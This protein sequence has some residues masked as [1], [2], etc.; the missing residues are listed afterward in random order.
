MQNNNSKLKIKRNVNL[1][2]YTSFNIGGNADY[3]CEVKTEKEFVKAI[4]WAKKEKSIDYFILGGGTNILVSDKGFRG[5]VI[6]CQMSNVK[7]QDNK[8]TAKAGAS[9]PKLLQFS[10]KHSLSGL[11]FLTG[12]PGTV[13]G[14]IAGNAGIKKGSISEALEKVIVLGEDGLIYDLNN[15]ECGFG[16]RKSRFQKTREIILEAVFNLKKENPAIIKQRINQ[17]L[18][19]RENQPKG[20]SVGSIFKNPS[21]SSAPSNATSNVAAAAA[22][23][24]LIEKADLKGKKIG[25]AMISKKHANWIVNLG[26]AKAEDVLKL[27]RL[28]KMEVKNKFGVEL[29]EEIR[30]VGEF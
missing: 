29:E 24:Y 15:K 1:A 26:N 25:D 6:K 21:G 7:C 13:G 2:Q 17:I 10:I 16:Y 23:G 8:I 14:A 18:K 11:G 4:N 12:I 9:L 28:A 27:I 20:K 3:F 19:T 5:L 30:L 22:A